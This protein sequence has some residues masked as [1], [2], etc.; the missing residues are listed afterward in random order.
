MDVKDI[1]SIKI[2]VQQKIAEI[3]KEFE[4]NTQLSIESIEFI[5]RAIYDS[6][7]NEID[8]QYVVESKVV[9]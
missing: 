6:L 7:G 2:E 4:S 5:R 1:I 3:L 9:L 8:C